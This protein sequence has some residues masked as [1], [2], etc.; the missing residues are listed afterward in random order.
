MVFFGFLP[1][2]FSDQG[3]LHIYYF[4][5]LGFFMYGTLRMFA[6]FEATCP[7]LKFD[8]HHSSAVG[9][10]LFNIFGRPFVYGGRLLHPQVEEAPCH[11]EGDTL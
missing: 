8:V 11:G 6:V 4:A 5:R 1:F 9:D 10:W 3:I 7:T 2:R